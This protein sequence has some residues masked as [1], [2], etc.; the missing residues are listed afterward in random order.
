[1]VGCRY[2]AKNTLDQNYLYLAEKREARIFPEARVV[3]VRPLADGTGKGGYEI[4][5]EK[6]TGFRHLRQTLKAKNVV[7]SAGSFGTVQLL[8]GCQER[9]SLPL[10]SS[11]LGDFVRTNNEALLG[12]RSRRRDVDYS[13][14]IAITSGVHVD[15]KTHIEMV[16]YS[17]GSDALAPLATLLTGDGPFWPRWMRLIGNVVRHP[18]DWVRTAIPFGASK[19]GAILLVMQ[20]VPSHLRY[21]MRRRWWWPF[22]RTLDSDRGGAEHVP[23]YIPIANEIAKRMAE[24]MD[25]VAQSGIVEVLFD[26]PTTA[27]ILGGCPIGLSP[28]DGVVDVQSRVYGYEGMWIVDGSIIPANLGVNPS[29][30]ITA[31]AEHAMS[32][33]PPKPGAAQRPVRFSS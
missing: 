23:V 8:M 32:H 25:G 13:K 6:S 12:V 19:H 2:H 21:R 7:F 22:R 20:P 27:H 4:T 26:K 28:E 3:D 33:V 29:L 5:Y 10:L 16:R 11:R 9:G 31:M 24:K 17:E 14:G 15:D 30:T 1:M 18:I